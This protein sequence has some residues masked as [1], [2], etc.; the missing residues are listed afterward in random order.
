MVD[1]ARH[2]GLPERTLGD[3]SEAEI[4]KADADY[5]SLPNSEKQPVG[6]LRG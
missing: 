4:S 3:I 5:D 6:R 2:T 1:P